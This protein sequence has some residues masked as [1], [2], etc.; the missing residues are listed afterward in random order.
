MDRNEAVKSARRYA[1]Y[2]KREFPSSQIKL[3]GS[4][5]RNTATV[6]SD[7]DVAVIHRVGTPKQKLAVSKRLWAIARECGEV[8]VEP[9]LIDH[10]TDTRQLHREIK[11]DGIDLI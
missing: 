10:L 1:G 8:N 2:V 5:A 11:R 6:N 3:F 7:I 9:I 4:Y